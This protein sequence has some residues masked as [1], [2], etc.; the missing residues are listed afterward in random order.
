MTTL[1]IDHFKEKLLEE[2]ATLEEELESVGTR[3]PEN[4]N[5]WQAKPAEFKPD[6]ADD[7]ELGDSFEEFEVNTAILK[8]LEIRYNDVLKAFDRIEKGTYGVC[9]ISGEHIEEARLEANPAA[10]TNIA[11][12]ERETELRE[13]E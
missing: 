13:K 8:Q 2:K 10:R 3:N 5:D 7:T 11:N 1:N 12:K 9:G 4:K 6:T